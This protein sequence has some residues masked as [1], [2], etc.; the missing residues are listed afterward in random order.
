MG[1]GGSASSVAA[2]A[3]GGVRPARD[4]VLA[5]GEGWLKDASERAEDG[6]ES[7][8][9]PLCAVTLLAFPPDAD[10]DKNVRTVSF[11]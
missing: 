1:G 7:T 11:P 4:G 5:I 6:Q 9:R 2:A 8:P 3:E 10:S